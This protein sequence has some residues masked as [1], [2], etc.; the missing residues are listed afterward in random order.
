M[1][2]REAAELTKLVGDHRLARNNRTV[3]RFSPAFG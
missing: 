3:R 2:D 1:L